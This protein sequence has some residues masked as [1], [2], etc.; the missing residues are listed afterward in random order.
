MPER[1]GR[2]FRRR[3]ES[4]GVVLHGEKYGATALSVRVTPQ[5]V[6]FCARKL[7]VP[8]VLEK[9]TRIVQV[10]ATPALLA[11]EPLSFRLRL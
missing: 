10:P 1:C 11:I 2:F 4:A 5:G 6:R 9:L 8:S 7:M 3:R